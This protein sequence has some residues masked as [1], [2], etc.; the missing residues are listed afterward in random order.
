MDVAEVYKSM[1]VVLDKLAVEKTALL[2]GNMGGKPYIEAHYMASE[3]KKLFVAEGLIVLPDEHMT[4]HEVIGREGRAPNVAV[5]IEAQYT[6]LSTKD[7]SAV[8]IKG[9]GDGLASGTAVASNI[10]ST[11]AF[12]NAFLRTFMV[13]EQSVEQASLKSTED[14]TEK[15]E[16]RAIATA[17]GGATQQKQLAAAVLELQEQVRHEWV[18]RHE[19]DPD[20]Y[21]SFGREKYGDPENWATNQT[22]LK[23]LI[24]SIKAGEVA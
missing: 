24:K 18:T 1:L 10:A 13:S 11:N 3:I 6:I 12:K 5:A 22:K 4:K 16:P 9:V 7:G 17:K 14:P 15:A 23:A 21:V 2:P 19:D 8:V 20:G